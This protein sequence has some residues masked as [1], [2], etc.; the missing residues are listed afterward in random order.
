MK[1]FFLKFGKYAE[2]K[3]KIIDCYCNWYQIL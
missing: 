2:N 1:F 3:I